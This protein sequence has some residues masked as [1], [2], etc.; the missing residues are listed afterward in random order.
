MSILVPWILNF[1]EIESGGDE[2]ELEGIDRLYLED[3]IPGTMVLDENPVLPI[4]YYWLHPYFYFQTDP[5]TLFEEVWLP[6]TRQQSQEVLM[7]TYD[8]RV[9][10]G[11]IPNQP[12]FELQLFDNIHFG[13][14]GT[15]AFSGPIAVDILEGSGDVELRTPE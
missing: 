13:P 10:G 15:D 12:Y 3:S 8:E 2:L 14:D 5:G 11:D 9:I 4:P 7:P 6:A 1:L